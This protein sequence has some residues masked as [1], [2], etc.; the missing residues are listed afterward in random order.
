MLHVAETKLKKK[1]TSKM[2]TKKTRKTPKNC[3]WL[4]C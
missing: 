1:H 3:E 2:A 4:V